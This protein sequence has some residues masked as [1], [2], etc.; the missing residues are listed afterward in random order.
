LFPTRA[1]KFWLR[2][3]MEMSILEEA[4]SLIRS[5]ELESVRG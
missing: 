3:A 1:A 5:M 2:F 4:A